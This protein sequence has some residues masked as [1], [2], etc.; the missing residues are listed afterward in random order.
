MQMKQSDLMD[1]MQAGIL[2][3]IKR[4][5]FAQITDLQMLAL[6]HLSQCK[7]LTLTE[8]VE[9]IG[10]AVNTVSAACSVL[11]RRR[12]ISKKMKQT[13]YRI[14]PYSLVSIELTQKGREFLTQ[15][16]AGNEA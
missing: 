4:K 5:Y 7:A 12:L 2:G 16:L 10:R 6:M 11:E 3:A 9:R 8:L 13:A 1:D 14:V 15:I